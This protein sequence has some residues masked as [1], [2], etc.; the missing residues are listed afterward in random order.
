MIKAHKIN[1]LQTIGQS[2]ENLWEDFCRINESAYPT[3]DDLENADLLA[4]FL[5]EKLALWRVNYAYHFGENK[6]VKI[7]D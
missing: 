2:A 4:G 7:R 6:G 1:T 5:L 3:D